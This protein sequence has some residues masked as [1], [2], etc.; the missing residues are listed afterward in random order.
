LTREIG[1]LVTLQVLVGI[2][3]ET[4]KHANELADYLKRSA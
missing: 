1:D 4:E 3:A 2:L